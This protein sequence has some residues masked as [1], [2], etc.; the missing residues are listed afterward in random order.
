M[1]YR[2]PNLKYPTD[3]WK[4]MAC[5]AP[6][7]KLVIVMGDLNLNLNGK[8]PNG[9]I[10]ADNKHL[11]V[12]ASELNLAIV[13]FD[14][15]HLVGNSQSWLDVFLIND[16]SKLLQSSQAPTARGSP[17]EAWATYLSLPR[18]QKYRCY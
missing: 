5:L 10:S 8:K 15:T 1:V 13:P 6:S 16:I 3:F 9:E 18:H 2:A 17:S 12:S 4:V 14:N 7:Y 11:R